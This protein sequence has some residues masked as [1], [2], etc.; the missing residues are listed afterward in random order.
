MA[1]DALS[2]LSALEFAALTISTL[3]SSLLPKIEESLSNN[4]NI[5]SIIR[6]FKEGKMDLS[7]YTWIVIYCEGKSD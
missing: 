3:V 5:Q 1:A 4:S 7:S 2:K 6:F